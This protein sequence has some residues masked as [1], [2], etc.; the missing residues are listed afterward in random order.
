MRG[1]RRAPSPDELAKLEESLEYARNFQQNL[2][3]LMRTHTQME[4]ARMSGVSQSAIS[5]YVR[6]TQDPTLSNVER[7]CKAVKVPVDL[8]LLAAHE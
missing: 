2:K 3:W 7:I 6:G 4:L 5:R 1:L 8:M